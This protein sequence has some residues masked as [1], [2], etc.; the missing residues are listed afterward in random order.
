MP[1]ER[2]LSRAWLAYET[3]Q[4]EAHAA[5]DLQRLD[6]LD[7]VRAALVAEIEQRPGLVRIANNFWLDGLPL[8]PGEALEFGELGRPC[9]VGPQGSTL[10]FEDGSSVP[11]VAVPPGAVQR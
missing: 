5:M 3:A 4:L 6:E 11:L 2:E 7:K 8:K 9:M 10:V 1:T